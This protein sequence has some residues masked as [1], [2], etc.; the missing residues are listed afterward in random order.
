[1]HRLLSLL[2]LWSLLGWVACESGPTEPES[3]FTKTVQLIEYGIPVSIQAPEDAQVTNQS[4]NFMQDV[5]LKGTHYYVQIYGTPATTTNCN[6]LAQEALTDLK[7]T[8][9]TFKQVVRQ[10]DCGFIYAI[11]T[12]NDTTTYYNFDYYAIKG[13]KA[14]RFTSTSGPL[15]DLNQSDLEAIYEAVKGQQ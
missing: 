10:D 8:D 13:N 9:P 2:L 15:V 6:N 3:T 1:M 11:Q 14:Y 12:E 4:D 7:T 5:L